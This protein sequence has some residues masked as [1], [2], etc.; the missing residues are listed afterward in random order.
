MSRG[1]RLEASVARVADPAGGK[2][3]IVVAD[4]GVGISTEVRQRLFEPYFTTRTGGT[5]LGLAIARRLVEL[6]A[7]TI[8]ILPNPDGQGT[9]AR[10]VLREHLD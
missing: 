6:M 10:V 5:G 7:G 3:E 8:E 9:L 1:G 2:V 4:T